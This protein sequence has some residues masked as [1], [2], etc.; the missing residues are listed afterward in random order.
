M[1][2][3]QNCPESGKKIKNYVFR[4]CDLIGKG[5]FARVYK[6]TNQLTSNFYAKSDE[7]VAIKMVSLD[8]LKSKKLEALVFE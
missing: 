2:F 6:G 1:N 3:A 7:T 8:D 5:N 4:Y